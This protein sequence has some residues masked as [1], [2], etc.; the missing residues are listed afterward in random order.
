VGTWAAAAVLA[1]LIFVAFPAS[2][3]AQIAWFRVALAVSGV[4]T[5][6]WLTIRALT[7]VS[8]WDILRTMLRPVAA[9][10]LMALG[11]A[12]VGTVFA[13][14]PAWMRLSLQLAGGAASYPLCLLGL[15]HAFG[16]PPG[17]EQWLLN[18]GVSILRS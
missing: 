4:F 3:A 15:W 10:S 2:D 16:R 12:W 8:T 7:V 9:T 6:I 11:V 17:A 18:R 13:D 5:V 14:A 1:L